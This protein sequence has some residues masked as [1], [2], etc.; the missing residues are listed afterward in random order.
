MKE[1]DFLSRLILFIGA[2]KAEGDGV[3]WYETGE[4]KAHGKFLNNAKDGVWKYLYK[5][6]DT[7]GEEFY[8]NGKVSSS[9][10]YYSDNKIKSKGGYVDGKLSGV[11]TYWDVNNRVIWEGS[12]LNGKYV[13]EWTRFF[14]N[15]EKMRVLFE[16]G[17]MVRQNL[18]G[19]ITNN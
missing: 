15:G 3:F 4:I 19:I 2:N 6:G 14:K 11:F 16:N 17:N 10:E 9:T 5:N 7:S 18:G 13:G 1:N 12:Y 8:T